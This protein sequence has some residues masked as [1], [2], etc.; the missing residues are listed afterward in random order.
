M[1]DWLCEN[2]EGEIHLSFGMTTH[3]EEEAIVQLFER[4]QRNQ[5]LVIYAC[6]SGYPVPFEDVALLEINRI[7]DAFETG[8][9]KLV[10]PAI[11]WALRWTLRLIPWVPRSSSAITPWIAPGRV[12]TMRHPSN[13]MEF[14]GSSAIWIRF[15][16]L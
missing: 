1:L 9:R 13:R 4:H 8:S 12:L 7:R 14:A 10:S 15:T 3:Q 5:D 11:T 2:Y 6:T 16:K